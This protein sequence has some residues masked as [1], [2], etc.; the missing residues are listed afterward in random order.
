MS[1]GVSMYDGQWSRKRAAPHAIGDWLGGRMPPPRLG[2][3]LGQ[4]CPCHGWG[5][6][7]GRMPP[8]TGFEWRKSSRG[9][10]SERLVSLL[11]VYENDWMMNK[12]L[13]ISFAITTMIF[14]ERIFGEDLVLADGKV[15]KGVLPYDRAT[16]EIAFET[17]TFGMG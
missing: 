15:S 13:I 11:Y 16:S 12:L 14:G 6:L 1:V 10:I 17:A 3:A 2:L 7:G 9:G 4:G 5:W 8:A